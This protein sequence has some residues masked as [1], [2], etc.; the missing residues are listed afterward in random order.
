MKHEADFYFHLESTIIC[1]ALS[2]GPIYTYMVLCLNKKSA[3]SVPQ[4]SNNV[5]QRWNRY[6]IFRTMRGNLILDG[7][8]LG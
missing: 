8:C 2:L 1:G 5:N 6:H 4:W 7:K 3:L